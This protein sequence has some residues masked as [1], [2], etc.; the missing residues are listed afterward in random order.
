MLT[1]SRRLHNSFIRAFDILFACTTLLF[2]S[3]LFLFFAVM[4]A[5]DSPGKI[6]FCHDRIG[7]KGRP[8]KMFKFRTMAQNFEREVPQYR[9]NS[10]GE[11]EPVIKKRDD[12]RITRTGRF[13][14]KY[15]LD[16][17][18]QLV[19]ILKNEM[20]IVGPRPPVPEEFVVYSDYQKKRLAAKPG[21]TGLA[22]INGRSDMDF[23]DIVQLDIQYIENQSLW[24]YFQ[25]ILRTIP[26]VLRG[27]SSY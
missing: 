10:K 21:I 5:M 6:L 2:L 27:K 16:E 14:R 7:K 3:P 9:K 22:Q 4:I 13:L 18:P 15:S 1:T 23:G 26:L 25:I 11:P 8:F 24:L 19:N 12:E 17:L 20:S